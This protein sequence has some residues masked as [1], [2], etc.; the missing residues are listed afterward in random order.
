M[1]NSF[2]VLSDKNQEVERLHICT[3]DFK[4]DSYIELGFEINNKTKEEEIKLFFIAPFINDINEDKITCLREKLA[5]RNN[6]RFIFNDA[7]TNSSP[8][9]GSNGDTDDRLG[10]TLSF[11][12]K[13]DLT[14]LP[15]K[16]LN[17]DK[18]N[19]ILT[20]KIQPKTG[21]S[22]NI[23]CRILI[24]LSQETISIAKK[25]FSRAMYIFDFKVNEIRNL[26]NSIFNIIDEK[27][28]SWCKIIS[29]F[30]LHIIP[31]TY[32]ISFVDDKKLKNIRELEYQAFKDYLPLTVKHL[33]KGKH[34]IVFNK[35][36]NQESYTFF[37]V[38]N[39]EVLGTKQIIFTLAANI[40]CSWFFLLA[41]P[42]QY[43]GKDL[44]EIPILVWIF[45][46]ISFGFIGYF[47]YLFYPGVRILG[48][49][50]WNKCSFSN[51]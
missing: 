2:F 41:R 36:S 33:K 7:I 51:E 28:L 22:Q 47:I 18:T 34:M 32:E 29:C 9:I 42:E 19:G 15:I 39:E 16:D 46:L 3:W 6:S 27:K 21:S 10:T 30:C 11:K 12:N 13:G 17:V 20:F 50:I 35:D 14:V 44:S 25:S 31:N 24:K 1:E 8:L 49:K 26:P 37:S 4:K 43:I 38:F 23:Y 48:K 5:S 45:G 40:I